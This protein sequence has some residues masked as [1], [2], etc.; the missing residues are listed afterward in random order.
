MLST[1]SI[2][3]VLQLTVGKNVLSRWLMTL[4]GIAKSFCQ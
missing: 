4:T 3:H 1:M 2:V